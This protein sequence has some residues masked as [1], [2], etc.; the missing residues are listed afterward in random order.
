MARRPSA[1]RRAGRPTRRSTPG[2]ARA[3]RRAAPGAVGA[4]QL[5]SGAT[6]NRP[7]GVL[8]DRAVRGEAPQHPLQRR[9]VGLDHGRHL[10]CGA[11]R[12]P[13]RLH[14]VQL[15]R[16]VQQLRA[17]V[18]VHQLGEAGGGF[19]GDY[20]VRG[21]GGRVG[22]HG[23][24]HPHGIEVV[25]VHLPPPDASRGRGG[26]ADRPPAGPRRGARWAV[27]GATSIRQNPAAGAPSVTTTAA[28][29]TATCVTAT[30]CPTAAPPADPAPAAAPPADP[31][32]PAAPAHPRA[33]ADPS[34][35]ATRQP[36]P[37]RGP[38]AR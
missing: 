33:P 35:A 3:W 22:V 24:A 9:G 28:R 12:T 19:R 20:G 8:D 27:S 37:P 21:G 32:P 36:G 23:H 1:P 13:Q 15:G 14:Q 10:R 31:A 30:A 11:R 2:P 16:D 18:A 34:G 25:R 4:E 29:T 38:A 7:P 5:T 17:E 26:A 6:E